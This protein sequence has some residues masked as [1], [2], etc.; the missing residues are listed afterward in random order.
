MDLDVHF[1]YRG[2]GCRM[3]LD[4]LTPLQCNSP[5]F[6][7]RTPHLTFS[8]FSLLVR[9]VGASSLSLVAL[10]YKKKCFHLRI[11]GTVTRMRFMF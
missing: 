1:M 7:V 10:G 11:L 5:F 3:G 6:R 4:R 2:S 9:L 8:L